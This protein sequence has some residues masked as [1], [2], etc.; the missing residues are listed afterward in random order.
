MAGYNHWGP[1]YKSSAILNGHAAG[2]GLIQYN[3]VVLPV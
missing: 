3:D 2:W 1:D